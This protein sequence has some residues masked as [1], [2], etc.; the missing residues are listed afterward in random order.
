MRVGLAAATV[1]LVAAAWLLHPRHTHALKASDTAVLADFTN[2]TGD[3]VFDDT[4][5]EALAAELQRS[6]FLSILPDREVRQTLKLIGQS[7]DERVTTEVAQGICQRSGSQAVIAWSIAQ[8][9]SEYVP[10]LN[11]VVCASGESMAS[12]LERA[13]KKEEVLGA[14]ARVGLARAYAMNGE[15]AKAAYQDFLTLWK[16]ADP[17]IPV[18]VAAKAEYAKLR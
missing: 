11:A 7:P 10:G 1:G 3:P 12:E 6:P 14:L 5:K 15:T 16:D 18:F 9:G 8:L 13:G 4:L 17:D 2:T